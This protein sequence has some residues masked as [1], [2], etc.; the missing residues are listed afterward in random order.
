MPFVPKAQKSIDKGQRSTRF[1]ERCIVGWKYTWASKWTGNRNWIRAQFTNCLINGSSWWIC[2]TQRIEPSRCYGQLCAKL[3]FVVCNHMI[4]R[5]ASPGIG[6][7]TVIKFNYC[8]RQIRHNY[9]KMS[10]K[11]LKWWAED[12]KRSNCMDTEIF[13]LCVEQVL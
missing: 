4:A 6:L 12:V 1:L 7:S 5:G 3:W 2:N 10:N 13:S 11:V 9:L 8:F